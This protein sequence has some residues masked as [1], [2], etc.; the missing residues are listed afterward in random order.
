MYTRL[1]VGNSYLSC[2]RVHKKYCSN[3][4]FF[5][6]LCTNASSDF[7]EVCKFAT[8][9]HVKSYYASHVRVAACIRA[10]QC[11][12]TLF[13]NH[14][15]TFLYTK[16]VTATHHNHTHCKWSIPSKTYMYT[17]H[18][19]KLHCTCMWYSLH[20]HL[21]DLTK[22][23]NHWSN[24]GQSIKKCYVLTTTS[25]V[26]RPWLYDLVAWY[27]LHAHVWNEASQVCSTTCSTKKWKIIYQPA[28]FVKGYPDAWV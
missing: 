1:V 21:L 4:A 5:T 15:N 14:H 25:L 22:M 17:S 28:I 6:L 19:T 16:M 8:Y 23:N 18:V 27:R 12:K 26:S 10:Q 13:P 20:I 9:T 7:N 2:I 3:W 24:K 11:K